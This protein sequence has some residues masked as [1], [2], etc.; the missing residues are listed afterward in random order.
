MH[1]IN[2]PY[3]QEDSRTNQQLYSSAVQLCKNYG[4]HLKEQYEKGKL[5]GHML[6][7]EDG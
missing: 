7:G 6:R 3:G 1:R 4:K 5:I 2:L